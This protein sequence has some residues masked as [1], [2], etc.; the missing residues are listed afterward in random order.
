[1]SFI[2]EMG[3]TGEKW[4]HNIRLHRLSVFLFF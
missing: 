1:V 3:K 2:T 4:G